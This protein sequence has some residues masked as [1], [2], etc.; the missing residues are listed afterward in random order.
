MKARSTAIQG[1]LALVGLV[2]A[3]F[4]WQR[5]TETLKQDGVVLV[6]ATKSSLEKLRY[7]DGNRLVALEKGDRFTVTYAWE[8]G[9]R[10]A[11]DAG[12][13]LELMDGGVDGGAV[14]KP[15]QPPPAPDRTVFANERADTA[16]SKFT[17][18]AGTRA[19]GK[20]SEEKLSELGLTDSPRR[21]TITVSGAARDFTISKT[22]AGVLGSYAQ[23]DRSKDV[24]LIS[25]SIFNELD[26]NSTLL[27]DRRLHTFKLTEFDAFTVSADGE[28][29]A[30][31]VSGAEVPA[32]LRIAPALT[33]DAPDELLKNWHE[34]VWNRLIVTEVLQQGELPPKGAPQVVLRVEYTL[35][36]RPVG[37][38][39]LAGVEKTWWAR[40]ENTPGWVSMHGGTEDIALEGRKLAVEDGR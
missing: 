27:I 2:A 8:P 22:V 9:K 39:E 32:S 23:D 7:S 15:V 38:L 40:S 16:W 21:L 12:V 6:E 37:W 10:P 30:F 24:F 33:P 4:T 34:K 35:K 5:P 13:G 14:V 29:R 20:L 18:F 28:R 3:Y 11:Y 25:S 1:G 17:P 19:L 26:P 31:V 36:G